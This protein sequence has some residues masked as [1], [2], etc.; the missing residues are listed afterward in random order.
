M[1]VNAKEFF[2][3]LCGNASMKTLNYLKLIDILNIRVNL[4]NS[5]KYV[6]SYILCK[7]TL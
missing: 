7:D 6:K 2:T 3:K 5:Y 4:F 1:G